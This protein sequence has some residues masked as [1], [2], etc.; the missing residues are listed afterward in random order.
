VRPPPPGLWKLSGHLR[1]L[2]TDI[3]TSTSVGTGVDQEQVLRAE[4]KRL[5]GASSVALVEASELPT[6]QTSEHL[7]KIRHSAAHVLA[8]AVQ[9]LF[10]NAKIGTGPWTDNG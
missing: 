7:L 9:K 1:C 5:A 6:N 4:L 8:M 10:P 2:S 3:D